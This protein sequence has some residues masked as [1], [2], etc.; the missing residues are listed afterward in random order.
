MA[1]NIY[2]GLENGSITCLHNPAY[3]R[4]HDHGDEKHPDKHLVWHNDD[5]EEIELTFD[6]SPFK[7][8][9]RI[10][11]GKKKIK[12]KV[13]DHTSKVQYKYD[14]KVTDSDGQ[15]YEVDPGLI[16]EP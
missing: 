1:V 3:M 9:E 8:G 4:I 5:G 2:V 11:R 16:I 6:E 7:S 12:E 10:V 15:E 14:V 13:K